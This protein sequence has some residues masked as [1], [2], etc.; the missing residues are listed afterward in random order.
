VPDRAL[1]QSN[2][3]NGAMR[4]LHRSGGKGRTGP[5]LEASPV[6]LRGGAAFVAKGRR[7]RTVPEER[8]ALPEARGS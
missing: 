3:E 5:P 8:V 2:W 6:R 4:P 1:T 7:L